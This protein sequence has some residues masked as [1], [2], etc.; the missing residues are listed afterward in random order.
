VSTATTRA[1][2]AAA[3]SDG[4]AVAQTLPNA[5][6]AFQRL[7][8]V[9]KEVDGLVDDSDRLDVLRSMVQ[10]LTKTAPDAEATC[11]EHVTKCMRDKSD[12]PAVREFLDYVRDRHGVACVLGY[13]PVRMLAMP[14]VCEALKGMGISSSDIALRASYPAKTPAVPGSKRFNASMRKLLCAAAKLATIEYEELAGTAIVVS[15]NGRASSLESARAG[16]VLHWPVSE[17]NALPDEVLSVEFV[18]WSPVRMVL[19]DGTVWERQELV[20]VSSG[21]QELVFSPEAS[22]CDEAVRRCE[23]ARAAAL[24]PRKDAGGRIIES[25]HGKRKAPIQII[26]RVPAKGA[27]ARAVE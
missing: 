11:I 26:R 8:H 20:S 15:K 10:L 2:D 17:V 13:L 1:S 5:A 16:E 27:I 19:R 9:L 21:R 7:A 22:W 18:S 24:T 6:L 23:E 12:M 4:G 14:D 25:K 3:S